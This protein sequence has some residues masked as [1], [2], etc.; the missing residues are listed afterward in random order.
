MSYEITN[1]ECGM[2]TSA[3]PVGVVLNL[4]EEHRLTAGSTT[5]SSSDPSIGDSDRG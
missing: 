5:A 3:E 2:A 1:H 4:Q